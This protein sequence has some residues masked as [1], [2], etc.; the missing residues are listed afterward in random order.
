MKA[1]VRFFRATYDLHHSMYETS[2]YRVASTRVQ[3][4]RRY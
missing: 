2:F 1:E 3:N 4:I